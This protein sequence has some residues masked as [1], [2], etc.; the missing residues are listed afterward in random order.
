MIASCF[1]LNVVMHVH[2][3]ML[4]HI[5]TCDGMIVVSMM[6]V[7]MKMLILNDNKLKCIEGDL[8]P[9]TCVLAWKC[10]VFK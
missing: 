10:N 5:R 4:C 8:S 7:R 6:L 3:S 1:C 9:G 2:I